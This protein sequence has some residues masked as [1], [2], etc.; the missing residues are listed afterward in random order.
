MSLLKRISMEYLLFGLTVAG[1]LAYLAIRRGQTTI[2]AAMF[3]TYLE[4]GFSVNDALACT[5]SV[6]I[7]EAAKH[8]DTFLRSATAPYGGSQLKMIAAARQRGFR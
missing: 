4:H 8:Q 7:A 2:R 5:S 3:L 1:L 6:A